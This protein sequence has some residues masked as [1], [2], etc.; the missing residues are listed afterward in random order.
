MDTRYFFDQPVANAVI[1][2]DIYALRPKGYG[3]WWED[4]DFQTGPMKT[5]DYVW[6]EKTQSLRAQTADANGHATLTFSANAKDYQYYSCRSS[7]RSPLK[8]CYVGIEVRATDGSGQVVTSAKAIRVYSSSTKVTMDSGDWLKRPGVGFD[9][10]V[11]AVDMNGQPAA[12]KDVYLKV[13]TYTDNWQTR[14]V[15]SFHGKTGAD[16]KLTIPLHLDQA[17][18]YELVLTDRDTEDTYTYGTS[19]W[20]YVSAKSRQG[21]SSGYGEFQIQAERN[22]YKPYEKARLMITSSFDGPALLT[23]ERGQVIH[24]RP[25]M[26]TAPLTEVEIDIIPEDAP[27][28]F[29]VVNAWKGE[30]GTLEAILAD[31]KKSYSSQSLRDA[32]L[33]RAEVELIVDA[34]ANRLNVTIEPDQASYQPRQEANLTVRVTDARNQPVQ[35]ELSL[36]LVDEAIFSLSEDTSGLIFDAFYGRRG[37]AIQTYDTMALTRYLYYS[38]GRGGGGGGDIVLPSGPRSNFQDT[39]IW[40]PVIRTNAGG[41]ADVR[42]TLPDN[43]TSW[44]VVVKAVTATTLVGE[45]ITHIV[46]QK[47][48]LVRPVMPLELVVG[49]TVTLTAMVHNY[50]TQARTVLASLDA[51]GLTIE[52]A[53]RTSVSL[54][55]GEMQPVTWQVTA[56]K[57]GEVSVTVR[58]VAGQ[59]EDAVETKL[60]IRQRAV[61]AVASQVGDFS[62][63]YTG[64]VVLPP[65][66]LSGSSAEIK[67]SRS[68]GGNVMEGLEYLTGYPYG[69][70]EQTMSRAL[71]NAAVGRVLSKLGL[72][73]PELVQKLPQLIDDGLQRLYGYQHDDGGWGWWFDDST[74]I[75]QSAWVVFGLSVT[76]EAGYPVDARVIERGAKYLQ[77]QLAGD[78]LKDVRARAY[79]LYSL[80][81]AGY[82]DRQQTLALVEN[83]YA[84]DPFSQAGLALALHALG[85]DDQARMVLSIL[86]AR[87]QVED[88]RAYWSANRADGEY[89]SKTMSSAIRTTALGLTAYLQIAPDHQRIPQLVRYLMDK[90]QVQGWG[91]TNETAYTLLALTD[92]LMLAEQSEGDIAYQVLLN[93]R[94]LARGT[95]EPGQAG[96]T[97]SLPVEQM[98]A[99][100][101]LVKVIQTGEGRLYYNLTSRLLQDLPSVDP[102]GALQ[103]SRAYVDVE[104][105]KRIQKIQPGQLVRVELIVKAVEEPLSYVMIED[106]LPAG[107]EAINEKLNNT[108]HD[109][110]HKVSDESSWEI[111]SRDFL[112]WEKF[113]YN[114][115]EIRGG[116]VSFFVTT[117][118]AG[119]VHL[120]T[121]LA[122]ATQSGVFSALPAEISA[123]YDTSAWGRSAGSMIEIGQAK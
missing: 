40:L 78:G 41:V 37:H 46:T 63:E 22:Q 106:H 80:A 34:G 8:E 17:G 35:A 42:V 69:C 55:A 85:E 30:Y 101:N 96:V 5:G 38:V 18:Y 67:L 95:F 100:P 28:I 59:M 107:L 102:S 116:R 112:Q 74:D 44:R 91:S 115:K 68:I 56:A 60:P 32:R 121:Y 97:I 72:E 53:S 29:V 73:Q 39:A 12:E 23:F 70:V 26:L 43:L 11:T 89:H 90:R 36:A 25:V 99:G 104:T 6:W 62:G 71:P 103:I 76:K 114:N 110:D 108:S 98:R 14:V 92:Y 20:V 79:V 75:Y 57:A 83:V 13:Q 61:P 21:D 49:D 87:A 120:F 105:N 10:T 31:Q 48:L 64:V 118:P 1:N 84:L 66:L 47:E 122:R 86:D 50:G 54:A 65:R 3:R 7:W 94:T 123:M 77:E 15:T 119:K 4:V 19:D 2:A 58:A 16:G 88:G 109:G 81:R 24:T 27:N 117:L 93:D 33:F 52:S 51:A 45:A 111:V 9:V 82:G 113:G